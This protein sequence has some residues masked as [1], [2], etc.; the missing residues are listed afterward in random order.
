[1]KNKAAKIFFAV[2]MVSF[3]IANFGCGK[4]K[5]LTD[6]KFY[7]KIGY[8]LQ[9]CLDDIFS[10]SVAGK[11][12]GTWNSTVSGPMGGTI[13]ITGTDSYSPSIDLTT[14]DMVFDMQ[15]VPYT[16]TAST[17]S[18]EWTSNLTFTGPITYK[19]TYSSSQVNLSH[20]SSNFTISGSVKYF[21]TTKNIS[22]TG[23][24]VLNRA[25]QVNCT[26]F[27]NSVTWK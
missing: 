19:G 14:C 5:E 25:S 4:D 23:S 22:T 3:L 27:G 8:T 6:D 10:Q 26:I 20:L 13:T 16:H 18:E 21:K 7:T 15:S 12:G 1:M 11:P 9:L 24:I 17:S 2:V